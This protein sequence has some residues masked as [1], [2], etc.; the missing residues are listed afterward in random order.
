M[1]K[2]NSFGIPL[3]RAAAA[4]GI[5]DQLRRAGI[6]PVPVFQQSSI[7]L[8]V[9]HDPYQQLRLDHYT[10]LVEQ[11][12]Q[13]T[14]LSDFG[15]RLGA[16]QNPADW[17]AFGYLVLNSPTIGA[18][19][20][21]L[22]T[23]L[24]PWQTGTYIACTRRRRLLSVDYSITHPSVT[25]KAQ[26]AEFSLAYIKTVVDRLNGCVCP[27]SRVELEHPPQSPLNVY[28]AYFGVTPRFERPI[29]RICYPLALERVAVETADLQLFPILKQHLIDMANAVPDSQDLAGSV[30]FQIRQLLPA[31]RCTLDNVAAALVL[32]PR[33]LQRRL[34]AQGLVFNERLEAIRYQQARDYLQHSEMAIKEISY[35]LGF[36]DNSAFTKAFKRWTGVTP[37]QYRT[38]ALQT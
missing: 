25:I 26:D 3:I 21:N 38:Q 16:E 23:F 36:N 9:I 29:N 31:Q 34:K 8:H 19:L 18:A 32:E 27:A 17:G 14:G 28:E 15:L 6:D 35:L 1:N 5:A 24:K 30:D 2:D 10:A 33:T 11:A 22:A 37:A 4:L 7:D 12:A 13:A 20:N